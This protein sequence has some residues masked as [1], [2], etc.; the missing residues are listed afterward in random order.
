MT[1][2]PTLN[3]AARR[4]LARA[5][6][7]APRPTARRYAPD[8]TAHARTLARA[9]EFTPDEVQRLASEAHEAF[10]AFK[11]G[12]G[13][14][15]HFDTLALIVN[16]VLIRAEAIDAASGGGDV[17]V[18]AAQAAQDALMRMKDRRQ[19]MGRWALDAAGMAAI[20]TALDVHDQLLELGTIGQI[21]DAMREVQRRM[22]SGVV[23]GNAADEPDP[24]IE[25][26]RPP[27]RVGWNEG[28]CFTHPKRVTVGMP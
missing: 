6:A 13:S 28:L 26:S 4:T 11:T 23:L 17:C 18:R 8:V 15:D 22:D 25:F 7:R 3:R 27:W 10:H 19:R 2:A 9:Q 20:E 12:G 5:Q 16:V 14:S 1:P 24:T 21:I